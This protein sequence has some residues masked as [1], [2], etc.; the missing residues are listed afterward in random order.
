[1]GSTEP[2]EAMAATLDKA[3]DAAEDEDDFSFLCGA[4]RVTA[5]VD[6][7]AELYLSDK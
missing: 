7:A 5:N 3:D 6:G 1:M 2:G 4:E